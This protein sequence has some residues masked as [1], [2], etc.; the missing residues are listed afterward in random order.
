MEILNTIKL[1][2]HPAELCQ[3]DEEKK[4]WQLHQHRNAAVLETLATIAGLENPPIL[5]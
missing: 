3:V 2:N 1:Y 5:T 4:F